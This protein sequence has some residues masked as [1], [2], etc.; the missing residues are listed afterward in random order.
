MTEQQLTQRIVLKLEQVGVVAQVF[1]NNVQI[2]TVD[3]LYRIWYLEVPAKVLFA[4]S[5][6]LRIDI[7]STVR[8]T[9][10]EGAR[11]TPEECCSEYQW[12]AVWANP[13]WI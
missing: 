7:E 8:Y 10:I 6:S 9:F 13:S 3:N 1:V 2:G 4:G 5:N 12:N 11:Y